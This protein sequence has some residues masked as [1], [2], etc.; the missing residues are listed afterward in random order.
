MA[1]ERSDG[2]ASPDSGAVTAVQRFG[3]ALNL[4]VHFHVAVVDGVHALGADGR[5]RFHALPPPTA[6]ECRARTELIA[7]RVR[8]LLMRR[9][10][11]R[12]DG[13][14]DDAGEPL[15][16]LDA[17]QAA[18][19]RNVAAMG[20]RAGRP[21][22]QRGLATTSSGRSLGRTVILPIVQSSES[23]LTTWR[24]AGSRPPNVKRPDSSVIVARRTRLLPLGADNVTRTPSSACVR[25]PV[26][27]RHGEVG[28]DQDDGH[29]RADATR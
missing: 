16:V 10:L 15:S 21:L 29:S 9:G 1:R 17:C 12:E 4:N 6:Q 8:R 14:S 27:P 7:S 28:G 23:R 22:R 25:N 19:A 2:L 26:A 24:A 13:A 20:A 3:G 18:S 11:L 5:L